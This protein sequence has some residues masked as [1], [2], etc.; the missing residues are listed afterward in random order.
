MF[1][2]VVVVGL[3]APIQKKHQLFILDDQLSFENYSVNNCVTSGLFCCY[4][5]IIY[6][7]IYGESSRFMIYG[8]FLFQWIYYKIYRVYSIEQIS[9]T[10]MFDHQ[11]FDQNFSFVW[12]FFNSTLGIWCKSNWLL[13]NVQKNSKKNCKQKKQ[14]F[15]LHSHL[16]TPLIGFRS[17][18][19]CK[20]NKTRSQLN[21]VSR[22]IKAL[23]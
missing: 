21:R 14:F 3:N 5:E 8:N 15:N 16:L 22:T 6:I 20:N 1:F 19:F 18:V 17:L 11:Q 23:L 9:I 2:F 12:M 4:I 7:S 10:S 13:S